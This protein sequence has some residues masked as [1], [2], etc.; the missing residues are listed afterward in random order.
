MNI[1][2]KKTLLA[3][4]LGVAA[5]GCDSGTPG[6]PGGKP[7]DK[8]VVGTADNAFTL[9]PPTLGTSLKQGEAKQVEIGIK[10]GKNFDQDVAVKFDAVPNGVT[11]DPASPTLKKGEESVKVS[12]KAA[13]D[14]ALG[15]FTVKV[16]GHPTTGPD[17][18]N[19]LKLSVSKK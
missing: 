17:A 9:S 1:S 18:S 16:I 6:G 14:A 8:P 19:D 5:T 10:R 4:A 2:I 3:L 7:A 12:V 11:F 15:D 13:D